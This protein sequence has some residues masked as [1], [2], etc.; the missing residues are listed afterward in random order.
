MNSKQHITLSDFTIAV[1]KLLL[2]KQKKAELV[3]NTRSYELQ[4]SKCFGEEVDQ[5][6]IKL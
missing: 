1:K 4:S 5:K 6:I 3:A 2:L